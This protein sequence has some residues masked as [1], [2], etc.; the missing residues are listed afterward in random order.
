MPHR[1]AAL[2]ADVLV[3]SLRLFVD[4]VRVPL[5]DVV[6]RLEPAGADGRPTLYLDS[7]SP[8]ADLCWAM[9]DVLR[10]LSGGVEAA[11]DARPVACR[12]VA[13]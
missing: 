6:A 13:V 1:T 2:T 12:L 11:L 9:L 10:V 5:L 7:G 4:V 3:A 8:P